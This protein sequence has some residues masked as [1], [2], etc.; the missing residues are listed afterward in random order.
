MSTP[1]GIKN[2]GRRGSRITAWVIAPK[3]GKPAAAMDGTLYGRDGR[4][5]IVRLGK[6]VR[7]GFIQDPDADAKLAHGIRLKG[8]WQGLSAEERAM[9]FARCRA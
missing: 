4:G 7:G 1:A 6:V 9:V 3:G 5:C 2:A 8:K